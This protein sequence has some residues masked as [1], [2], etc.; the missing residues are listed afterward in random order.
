MIARNSQWIASALAASIAAIALMTAPTAS[1][2][3]DILLGGVGPSRSPAMSPV[4]RR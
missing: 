3:Q 4:D 2:A 1:R